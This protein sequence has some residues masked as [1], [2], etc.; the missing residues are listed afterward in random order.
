MVACT[1]TAPWQ[2]T[3]VTDFQ[4]VA[5][6]WEGLL[7]SDDPRKFGDDRATLV[8]DDM[9]VYGVYKAKVTRTEIRDKDL[10]VDYRE[11]KLF[12]EQGKLVD[13]ILHFRTRIFQSPIIPRR[14]VLAGCA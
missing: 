10:S 11:T 14:Y 2:P 8:I 5:G 7:T 3:A 13:S 1:S 9:G 12:A 6:K 4:S